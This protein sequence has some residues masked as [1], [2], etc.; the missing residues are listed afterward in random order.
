MYPE[1]KAVLVRLGA[2]KELVLSWDKIHFYS[3]VFG[4]LA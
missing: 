2:S 3:E 1:K 4:S